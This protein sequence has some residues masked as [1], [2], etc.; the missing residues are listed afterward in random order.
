MY[1]IVENGR[2]DANNTEQAQ[3]VTDSLFTVKAELTLRI[4]VVLLGRA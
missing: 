3:N 2:L 4:C 1:L